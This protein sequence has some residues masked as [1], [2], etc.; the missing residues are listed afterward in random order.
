MKPEEAIEE[1]SFF[2]D[3]KT[4]SEDFQ[5]VCRTA[6]AALE[7]QS[8]K[9]VITEP[10]KYDNRFSILVCPSCGSRSGCETSDGEGLNYCNDCGQKLSGD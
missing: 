7:K 1:L 9:A 5:D 10:F 8:P 3:N 4:F 2:V 6:I